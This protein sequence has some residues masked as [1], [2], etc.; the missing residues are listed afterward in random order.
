MTKDVRPRDRSLVARMTGNILAGTVTPGLC[1][2]RSDLKAQVLER[3]TR[4]AVL[5]AVLTLEEI[6]KRVDDTP[7]DDGKWTCRCGFH[8]HNAQAPCGR[9]SKPRS[10]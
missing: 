10:K 5:M 2:L 1:E 3:A 6:D 9:C 7:D 4:T 8:N